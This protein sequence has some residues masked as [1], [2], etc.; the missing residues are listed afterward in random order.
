MVLI[1]MEFYKTLLSMQTTERMYSSIRQMTSIIYQGH[2]LLTLS[3][4][5]LTKLKTQNSKIFS[6]QRT[7]SLIMMEL[8]ITGLKDIVLLK[9]EKK[10]YLT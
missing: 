5:S 1:Q 2:F 4:E 10:N 6:I 8:E 7:I 3:Q 9:L